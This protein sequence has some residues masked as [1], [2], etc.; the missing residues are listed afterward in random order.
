[1]RPRIRSASKLIT[2]C[3]IIWKTPSISTEGPPWRSRDSW[4]AD[5][6]VQGSEFKV[7]GGEG[8][9]E[10]GTLNRAMRGARSEKQFP[11]II[12]RA[13]AVE[14]GMLDV[15]QL[16]GVAAGQDAALEAE[17]AG[18]F[19]A[20][21]GLRDAANFSGETDFTEKDRPRIEGVFP[22]AR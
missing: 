17:L 6:A 21:L 15:F 7:Q 11:A 14:L 10:P 9:I 2:S 12:Q 1:M 16:R 5:R 22:A 3:K 20:C 18:F 8:K 4:S 13:D 19:D